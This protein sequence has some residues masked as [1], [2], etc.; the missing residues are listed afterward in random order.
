V[1]GYN[2]LLALEEAGAH[3]EY[4][5][6]RGLLYIENMDDLEN[7]SGPGAIRY[8]RQQTGRQD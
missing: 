1:H 4:L 8:R 7:G 5:Y 6:Q 2:V 3:V